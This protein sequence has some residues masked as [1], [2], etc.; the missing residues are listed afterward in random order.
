MNDKRL[1]KNVSEIFAS[2]L[3]ISAKRRKNT[4]G[5]FISMVISLSNFLSK[6]EILPT[7]GSYNTNQL[8]LL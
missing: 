4:P 5:P 2:C 6:T 1:D 8:E 7:T 3:S